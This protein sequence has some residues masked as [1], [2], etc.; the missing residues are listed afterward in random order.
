MKSKILFVISILVALIAGFLFG[1]ASNLNLPTSADKSGQEPF[2][3]DESAQTVSM[4]LDFGDG[5]FQVFDNLKFVQGESLFDI[6]KRVAE[7]NGIE[8]IFDP[9]GEFGVFVRQIKDRKNGQENRYWQYW[10][11]NVQVQLAADRYILKDGDVIEWQF[12]KS[13]Y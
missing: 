3:I 12:V 5:T 9:P 8:F 4:M 6:T 7:D 11:N 2:A 1:K 10:V 13:A